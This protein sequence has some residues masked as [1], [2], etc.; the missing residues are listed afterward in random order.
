[1]AEAAHDEVR[2][3]DNA[4]V[5]VMTQLRVAAEGHLRRFIRRI[6]SDVGEERADAVDLDVEAGRLDI[7]EDQRRH[8]IPVTK[9]KPEGQ[10]HQHSPGTNSCTTGFKCL[11]VTDQT[12][13]RY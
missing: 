5:A 6:I 12:L 4:V 2:N 13:L 8:V 11:L 9:G 3:A 10:R 1:M 7:A